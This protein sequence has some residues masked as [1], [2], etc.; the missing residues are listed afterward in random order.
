[1]TAGYRYPFERRTLRA[2]PPSYA[3]PIDIWDIDQTYLDTRLGRLRDLVR[4]ALESAA[5]KRARPGVATLLRALRGGAPASPPGGPA[6]G[7]VPLF[8]I[9]ASPPQLRAVL[10]E[11]M[12]LDG[13]AWDGIALKDHLALL[14]ARRW[15]ELVRHVAYKL[16]ALLTYRLDWPPGA[17]EWLYGDD[18]ESDPRIYSLYAGIRA[19]ELGGEALRAQLA[20]SHVTEADRHA[21]VALA[22]ETARLCP[23]PPGG[24]VEGIFIL[25][26]RPHGGPDLSEYPRV[27]V[28]ADAA[29]LARELHRRG[30][31]DQQTVERVTE[32]VRRAAA[33]GP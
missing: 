22:A 18:G 30:R 17:R 29:E 20:H 5:D 25:R 31:I 13:I 33:A 23:P 15:R 2:L 3:G 24:S 32:E 27:T 4:T 8:F 11:K 16:T 28:C 6:A 9:S 7:P 14:A 12:R 10:E 26:T 21:I 1:M 19:G